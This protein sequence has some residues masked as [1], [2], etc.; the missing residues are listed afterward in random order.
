MYFLPG[1]GVV[2]VRNTNRAFRLLEINEKKLTGLLG[3]DS[4]GGKSFIQLKSPV[5]RKEDS[6]QGI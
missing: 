6:G 1:Q 3:T 2:G 4:D 5:S